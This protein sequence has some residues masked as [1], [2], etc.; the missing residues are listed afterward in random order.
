MEETVNLTVF[1]DPMMGLSYES[2]PILDALDRRYGKRLDIRYVMSV[3]VRDVCDFMTPTE[4]ALPPEEAALE[5]DRTL[6][7]RL[8]IHSLPT[9]V[10]Q[11]R[12]KALFLQSFELD[13]FVEAID[14][15]K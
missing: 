11:H 15:I 14:H 7:C 13:D 2:E 10:I 3:L 5:Q 9:Y 12:G 6:T 4:R 1:T 8:G